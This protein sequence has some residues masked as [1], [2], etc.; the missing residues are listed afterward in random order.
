[1]LSD[2][3]NI[4]YLFDWKLYFC[5]GFTSLRN[6][7]SAGEC[8]PYS[9][10]PTWSNA[11]INSCY[12]LAFIWAK[13]NFPI[14]EIPENVGFT[15]QSSVMVLQLHF[16]NQNLVP[17][18]ADSSG[19]IITYTTKLRQNSAAAML[20]GNRMGALSMALPRNTNFINPSYYCYADCLNVI[21]IFN[22]M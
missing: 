9:N 5:P 22:L 4:N 19:I 20:V 21:K 6:L 7:P 3:A 12:Y 14:I 11:L 15:P 16:R 8:D 13:G 1:M 10:I 18:I 2:P 17:N